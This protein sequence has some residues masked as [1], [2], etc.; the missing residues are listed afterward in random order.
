MQ[1]GRTRS[2]GGGERW[3]EVGKDLQGAAA[4]A[5]GQPGVVIYPSSLKS[6]GPLLRLAEV[7]MR[8]KVIFASGVGTEQSLVCPGAKDGLHRTANGR[9]KP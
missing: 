7:G 9:M 4:P 8:C 5:A 1:R 3:W 6:S 2:R